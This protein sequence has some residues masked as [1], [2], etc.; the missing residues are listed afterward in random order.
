MVAR[1]VPALVLAFAA[2][3][4]AADKTTLD[5]L[6]SQPGLAKFYEPIA[7]AFMKAH[8]DIEI[9]FRAPAKDYDEG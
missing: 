5:V 2:G 6:Y 9:K 1:V 8:P 7:Q 3:S 4:A